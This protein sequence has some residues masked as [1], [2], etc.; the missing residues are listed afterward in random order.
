METRFKGGLRFLL[1]MEW[2]GYS[3]PTRAFI[4]WSLS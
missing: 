2:E 1:G 3:M 4:Y